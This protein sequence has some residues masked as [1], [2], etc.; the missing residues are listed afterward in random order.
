MYLHTVITNW[1]IAGKVGA[2]DSVFLYQLFQYNC[3]TSK[4]ADISSHS[5]STP[6]G[7][8]ETVLS[9]VIGLSQIL[10]QHSES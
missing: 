7:K 1:Q 2:W 6:N 3:N 5:F 10:P 8:D 4:Q 9:M